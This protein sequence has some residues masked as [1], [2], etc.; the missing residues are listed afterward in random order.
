ME[1]FFQSLNSKVLG[2]MYE[3]EA[4]VVGLAAPPK[5][6]ATTTVRQPFILKTPIPEAWDADEDGL[7]GTWYYGEKASYKIFRSDDG[8]LMFREGKRKG[9]LVLSSDDDWMIAS[10]S[11]ANTSNIVG[12]I[13]L[14]YKNGEIT[15]HFR[16]GKSCAGDYGKP[17][18]ATRERKTE[19]TDEA[20]F[21]KCCDTAR[22]S[23]HSS[24][25]TAVDIMK[26]SE[27]KVHQRKHAKTSMPQE[28]HFVAPD[29]AVAGV[30]VCLLGPHGDP[31]RVA[32]PEGV[33]P[34][35]PCSIYLGPSSK[36]QVVV[37]EGVAPGHPVVF[38]TETGETYNAVVPPGKSP[39]DIM[40][41]VPPVLLI[42]V[43]AGAREGE[44]ILYTTPQGTLAIVQIP[45][46][47]S[48]GHYFTTLLPQ[49]VPQVVIPVQC[50]PPPCMPPVVA[51]MAQPPPASTLN[52]EAAPKSH[53]GSNISLQD[54]VQ[55]PLAAQADACDEGDIIDAEP[56]KTAEVDASESIFCDP[57]LIDQSTPPK[58]QSPRTSSYGLPARC[59]EDDQENRL[60][61]QN[62]STTECSIDGI[63]E[64]SR[65]KPGEIVEEDP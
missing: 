39:G 18:V 31:I 15:S 21:S 42:Q 17:V 13:K 23:C 43:P 50:P 57:P 28:L 63:D 1:D 11:S 56:S 59:P 9:E 12:T 65:D 16:A 55:K 40:D 2:V 25:R 52:Q 51:A 41:I 37:P 24:S 26:P 14:C 6:R 34:G 64:V 33:Q 29:D 44:E 27:A 36:Y 20:D 8:K 32:L 38:T 46:G 47:F 48:P 60:T 58:T 61:P 22:D 53:S 10:L 45:P 62:A 30:P 4:A 3:V 7:I 35:K 19:S 54:R 49:V 5:K